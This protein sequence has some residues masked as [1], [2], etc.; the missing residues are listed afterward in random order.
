MPMKTLL[1]TASFIN[2]SPV[3]L[4]KNCQHALENIS[5]FYY[6]I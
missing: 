6:C 1:R 3:A 5:A 2:C 4:A